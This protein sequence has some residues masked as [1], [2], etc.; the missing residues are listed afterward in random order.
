MC[1]SSFIDR[2]RV[3]RI[4]LSLPMTRK[5]SSIGIARVEPRQLA[6]SMETTRS[7]STG[8]PAPSPWT[9]G[10][11][12]LEESA[13]RLIIDAF[14][15]YKDRRRLWW[16]STPVVSRHACTCDTSPNRS[17]T[18]YPRFNPQEVHTF[19]GVERRLWRSVRCKRTCRLARRVRGVTE[20]ARSPSASK[21]HQSINS[22]SVGMNSNL[23]RLSAS[24]CR[25][26]YLVNQLRLSLREAIPGWSPIT[27][28]ID[29]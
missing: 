26:F 6:P 25:V 19:G 10:R 28:S 15:V 11:W 2:R 3:R 29:G 7:G 4:P 24:S 23:L 22:C 13:L 20:I 14:K 5:P 21:L 9:A 18:G 27:I 17:T 1:P 16:S 8:S 12:H